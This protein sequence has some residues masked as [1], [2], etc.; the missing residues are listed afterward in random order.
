MLGKLFKNFQHFLHANA[1]GR[2]KGES[3]TILHKCRRLP[4]KAS[5]MSLNFRRWEAAAITIDIMVLLAKV[6]EET[7]TDEKVADQKRHAVF[8]ARLLSHKST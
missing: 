7:K 3:S 1:V 4:I 2:G 8:P 5:I 6:V